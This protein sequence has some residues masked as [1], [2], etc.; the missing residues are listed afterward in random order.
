MVT[1]GLSLS[2]WSYF[3]FLNCSVWE[4]IK[5]ILQLSRHK[6]SAALSVLTLTLPRSP[7]REVRL[8]NH[9]QVTRLTLKGNMAHCQLMFVLLSC[10]LVIVPVESIQTLFFETSPIYYGYAWTYHMV[11]HIGKENT[12]SVSKMW[13]HLIR[14]M[15]MFILVIHPP[16]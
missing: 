10:L 3:N 16:V 4:L 5:P 11:Q 12:V 15:E 6:K 13:P 14:N 1:L 2:L 9:T 7:G 8:G